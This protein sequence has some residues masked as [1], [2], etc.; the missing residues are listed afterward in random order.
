MVNKSKP[1]KQA[2]AWKFLKFLDEPENLATW[3]IG[4]GYIPIRK[5]SANS[6]AMQDYWAQNPAF[7][8][9]YDQLLNGPT[10]VATSGSVI[11]DYKGVRDAV[12]DAENSMFL[13]GKDPTAALK[14]AA[15]GGTAAIDEYNTRIGA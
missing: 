2:A 15:Q 9:A 11:G 12:R 3:A 14:A 10:N 5:S 6:K 7:K 4:T 13:E 1:E 8:V